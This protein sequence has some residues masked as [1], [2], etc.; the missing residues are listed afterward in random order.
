ML[1]HR[2]ASTGQSRRAHRRC[3]AA[4][5]RF[6]DRRSHISATQSRIRSRSL[7]PSF[8][9]MAAISAASSAARLAL[10]A[11][12]SPD[13]R[14]RDTPVRGLRTTVVQ[15]R[16]GGAFWERAP[17]STKEKRVLVNFDDS[18]R[19]EA[20][21]AAFRVELADFESAPRRPVHPLQPRSGNVAAPH[22]SWHTRENQ[23][24]PSVG[25][26]SQLI[27]RFHLSAEGYSGV[28]T[29]APVSAMYVKRRK[30]R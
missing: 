7:S 27:R 1:R 22:P 16:H 10:A 17:S 28:N 12:N 25:G 9:S 19:R 18:R 14:P 15:K 6:L 13:L 21:I 30:N 29:T 24:V 5:Y 4:A 23:L 26:Q 3:L 8:V 11:V 20:F 2:L